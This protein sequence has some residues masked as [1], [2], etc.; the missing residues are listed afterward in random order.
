MS[1]DVTSSIHFHPIIRSLIVASHPIHSSYCSTS[2]IKLV[3]TLWSIW[4]VTYWWKYKL[5]SVSIFNLEL[6]FKLGTSRELNGFTS[7]QPVNL[8]FQVFVFKFKQVDFPFQV[9]NYLFFSVHLNYWLIFYV[10]C[11]CCI[12]KGTYSL[13]CPHMGWTHTCYH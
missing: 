1:C 9:V 12:I 2:P 8:L 7:V 13:I 6:L 3:T 4:I 11:S 10:H 5:L